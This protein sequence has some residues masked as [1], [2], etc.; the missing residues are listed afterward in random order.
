TRNRLRIDCSRAEYHEQADSLYLLGEPSVQVDDSKVKGQV[1]RL[2]MHGEEIRSLLV[3]GAAQANSLEPATD[4]SAARQSNVE[5]DS[6]F[7]A[8]KEK[9]IDSVQVFRNAKGS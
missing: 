3:K 1:M 6:L 8:F 4:T 2:G 9:A 5:G 7:L